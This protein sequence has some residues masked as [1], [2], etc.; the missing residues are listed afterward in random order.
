MT[1]TQNPTVAAAADTDE[2]NAAGEA[3]FVA[4]DVDRAIA[5]FQAV[6]TRHPAHAGAHGNL[7]VVYWHMGENAKAIQHLMAAFRA[8]SSDRTI[9]LNLGKALCENRQ[10]EAATHILATFLYT[11]PD[12]TEVRGLMEASEA[13][14]KEHKAAAAAARADAPTARPGSGPLPERIPEMHNTLQTLLALGVEVKSILDVGVLHGTD[15]LMQTFPHLRHHLF[16]PIDEHFETI[17]KNYAGMDYQ[18]HHVALSGSDGEAWQI[19]L[20]N[21]GSGRITH[22]QISDTPVAP[23]R[24]PA[25][26]GREGH[27]DRTIVDCRPIRKARLDTLVAQL[28][29][30]TPYLLKI[31]VDGHEIP[32]L[33]G[34][35]DT[36]KQAS[37]VVIEATAGTLLARGQFLAEHGFQLFDIVDFAYYAGVL[38]QVDLIFV[39]RDLVDGSPKLHPMQLKPFRPDQWYPVSY[40]CFRR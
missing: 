22:S 3:F 37:V 17:R 40:K 26:S 13:L 33:E 32:I 1:E 24:Q 20:C 10:Y 30:P 2:L 31:D 35:V 7:G 8:D 38:H 9:A 21:D 34:A 11:A 19:G 15:A 16:E 6:L 23:G 39:R 14:A 4:G 27:D 25:L 12:D 18:L 28:Q 29:A 5:A 36:L